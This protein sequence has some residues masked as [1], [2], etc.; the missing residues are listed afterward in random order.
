[1]KNNKFLLYSIV[2][3]VCLCI[4]FSAPYLKKISRHIQFI[5]DEYMPRYSRSYLEDLNKVNQLKIS[6]NT[7][8]AFKEHL[9]PNALNLTLTKI[10]IKEIDKNDD[11]VFQ[12][13]KYRP[14]FLNLVKKASEIGTAYIDFH[15]DN[16]LI[17]Q[18]NGLF[19]SV[20]KKEMETQKETISASRIETNITKFTN[21]LDFYAPGKFG[22]K[23]ILVFDNQLYVSFIR[24]VSQDCFNISIISA[25]INS[26]LDFKYFYRPE[27]CIDRTTP[28]FNAEQTG[29][30]MVPYTDDK[31]L[32]S[33]GDFRVRANA[34]D[35]TNEFGKIL[36]IEISS[37][38]SNIISIGHRNPQGL[39]FSKQ[40]KDIWS[41]E[42]GP[43]GG[44]EVNVNKIMINKG[45]INFGWPVASYGA[46]Y[47]AGEYVLKDEGYELRENREFPAYKIAPLYKSH[48]RHGFVEPIVQFTPSVGIS[49]IAEVNSSYGQ[50]GAKRAFIIG[51]MGYSA[52][53]FIPSVSLLIL[54][55]DEKNQLIS[56]EQIN[57]N[58]RM[59]DL[60]YDSESQYTYFAGD[61]N[62]VIGILMPEKKN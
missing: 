6:Q 38:N 37:G 59:R 29:G 19:F 22:L 10:P 20:P 16:I 31:I 3:I 12:I 33:T 49:Q 28:E 42:H 13:I 41:T 2:G 45:L 36:S 46:H 24:E 44:D 14:N 11:G 25:E 21:Y 32:F 47:G 51:T 5:A 52:S 1:M 35:L 27:S 23:D 53:K 15:K 30:R 56:Q 58:E 40:Y 34:Q 4:F 55:F 48:S 61:L 43:Y 9:N 7:F 39:Y 60:I 17:A 26:S 54:S 57:M 18:E 8:N 50:N 62:G